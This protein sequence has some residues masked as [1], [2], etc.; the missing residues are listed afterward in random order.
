MRGILACGGF[1][2]A[3]GERDFGSA[4]RLCASGRPRP[5]TSGSPVSVRA[6]GWLLFGVLA[7]TLP[8]PMW[9]PFG[10]FAPAVRYAILL[11][12]GGAVAL[13]EG[14]AGPVPGILLLLAAHAVAAGAL[15]GLVAW[16]AS[17]ALAPLSARTRRRVV[18]TACAG[19]L[20]AALLLE[21]YR[22]PFGSAPT[23]GLLGLLS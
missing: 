6:S 4:Q 12:A 17:R 21:P 10:A 19:I 16:L 1:A 8:I 7:F 14:A 2:G 23:H 11:S 20:L 18:W 3:V 13:A 15:A 9:G 22:T 5:A